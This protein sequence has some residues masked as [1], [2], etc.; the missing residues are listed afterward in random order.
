[1]GEDTFGLQYTA[2]LRSAKGAF[3]SDSCDG[4]SPTCGIFSMG[5]GLQ[6]I[7]VDCEVLQLDEKMFSMRT[8]DSCLHV[9]S[10][11]TT[12]ISP[13]YREAS[14]PTKQSGCFFFWYATIACSSMATSSRWSG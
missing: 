5:Y 13:L 12:I 4:C 6:G 2:A 10:A 3:E 8:I 9:V 1:M 11:Y 7:L 14:C